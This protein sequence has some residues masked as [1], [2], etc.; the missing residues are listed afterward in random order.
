MKELIEA[1]NVKPV[2]DR[3]YKL[4]EITQAFNYFA[5]GHARGKILLTIKKRKH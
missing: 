4:G 3:C 1:G 5:E 2:I